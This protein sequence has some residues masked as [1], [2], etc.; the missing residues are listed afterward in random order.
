[1]TDTRN[2]INGEYL[3][4]GLQSNRFSVIL[5]LRP[6]AE[7]SQLQGRVRMPVPD[8][9][10]MMLPIL[11]FANRGE[12]K[13]ADARKRI[14]DKFNLSPKD[15]AELVPSGKKTRVADRVNWAMVYLNM[16][17]LLKRP[18]RGHYVI[19]DE[20]KSVLKNPPQRIDIPFLEKF[21]K[22]KDARKGKG[23][24]KRSN[25]SG[26]RVT[27]PGFQ[28]MMLPILRFANEGEFKPADARRRISSE[29][30][31]SHENREQ[32]VPS[33]RKTRLSDRVNWAMVY[34]NMAGLLKR[35][36]RGHYV[37]TNE[38]KSVLKSSPKKID[39]PFLK[40]YDK[41]KV[42]RKGKGNEKKSIKSVRKNETTSTPS[43]RIN[44]AFEEI[45]RTLKEEL[46]RRIMASSPGAF[47]TLVVDLMIG[48]GYAAKGWGERVGKSGDGGIDGVIAQ[49][50][51]GLDGIYLQAKR[52]KP[53]NQIGVDKIR[54]FA[55]ALDGQGATKGVFVTTSNF[56]QS[57]I[58]FA[59]SIP[60]QKKLRLIDGEEL[61]DLM[62][63]YGIA[64][65]DHHKIVMKKVD[66]DYFEE[67]DG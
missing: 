48:M 61:T 7:T 51:L 13:P 64:V 42:A 9:Q 55:G 33:G 1:M 21:D 46:L 44:V 56:A 16:A 23:N 53:E 24:E 63:R 57:A 22:F 31:L 8:Y 60:G 50:A 40:K 3:A 49:D 59:N 25:K 10:S 27:V 37:I 18:K 52:Y 28:S 17:G 29:F 45:N 41:F 32:L 54:E 19:T 39:I 20:G 47:E 26:V 15:R 2:G 30:K 36:K 67:I 65:R 58:E 62:L 14:S 43:E 5:G 12:F 11:R 4:F 35:P 34:L 66:D 38:G 6:D